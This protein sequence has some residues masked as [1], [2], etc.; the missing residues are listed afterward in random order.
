MPDPTV[1]LRLYTPNIGIFNRKDLTNFELVLF[2]LV[3]SYTIHH[4]ALVSSTNDNV[5]AWDA[6]GLILSSD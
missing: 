5:L 2:N 3:L 6:F 1:C 4:S